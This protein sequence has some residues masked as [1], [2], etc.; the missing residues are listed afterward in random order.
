MQKL[1]IVPIP[2]LLIILL[3]LLEA[4]RPVIMIFYYPQYG[5]TEGFFQ[6]RNQSL[7]ITCGCAGLL[8]LLVAALVSH[9]IM[10]GVGLLLVG[11]AVAFTSSLS[12]GPNIGAGF[13]FLLG[14]VLIIAGASLTLRY[15]A[16]WALSHSK[17]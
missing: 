1:L 9:R 4:S 8:S 12:G 13:A 11:S 16:H 6:S 15:G 17:K 14:S 10:A 3:A 2:E 5:S 7:I